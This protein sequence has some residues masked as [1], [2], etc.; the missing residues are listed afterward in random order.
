MVIN[1]PIQSGDSLTIEFTAAYDSAVYTPK[2]ILRGITN[3][4]EKVGTG[5]F[6]IALTASETAAFDA[7]EYVYS[8]VLFS[9]DDRVTI[10]TGRVNVLVDSSD[11]AS[12]YRTQNEKTL[13]N[14]EAAINGIATSGQ[15]ETSINGRS[16]KRMGAE[17]LIKLHSYFTRKVKE[18][19]NKAKFGKGNRLIKVVF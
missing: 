14:L 6:T 3:K 16:I 7:G 17:E 13:A 8:I 4:Y 1:K 18:E 15:L 12:D 19:Q 2:L 10:E 5:S 11:A 9:D